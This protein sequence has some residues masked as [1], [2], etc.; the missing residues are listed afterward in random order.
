MDH[1]EFEPLRT[2]DGHQP[3]GIQPLRGSRQLTQV[4]LIREPYETADPIE[5]TCDRE[6][7]P[8]R[9]HPKEVHQ[10]PERDTTDAIC[11]IRGSA[12]TRCNPGALEQDGREDQ[13][14]RCTLIKAMQGIRQPV[15][16]SPSP[17]R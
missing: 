2:V 10:L 7:L 4:A 5:K 12:E 17:C 8:G 13:P 1:R 15:Q 9:L 11:E 16:R 14:W 3:Y 6:A